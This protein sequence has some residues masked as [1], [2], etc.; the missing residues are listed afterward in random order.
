M[1]KIRIGTRGSKLALFQ[2][3]LV[4]RLLREKDARAEP[5][6]EV[7]TTSGDKFADKPLAEAGG[8]GLF[9]KEIEE[10]LLKG[11]IDLAVHSLK[12]LPAEIPAPLQLAAVLERADARDVPVSSG[13][14]LDELASG[15]KVGTCSPRREAQ[16]LALRKDLEVVPLRGNLDTRLRK[17]VKGEVDATVLA[18]AGLARMGWSNRASEVFEPERFLPAATQGIIGLETRRNGA[19]AESCGAL[20][21]GPSMLA[22]LAERAFVRGVGADCHSAVAA[23]AVADG[24]GI[25]LRALAADIEGTQVVRGE[26]RGKN[27]DAEV[28]GKRLAEKL[29][30]QGAG[31]LLRG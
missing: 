1:A 18:A 22:A 24:E 30:G 19:A 15:A 25:T 17:V 7:I 28:L 10:A 29:L 5:D 6:L 21:H 31:E 8:K 2:A 3:E 9:V 12:D 23:Y 14:K 27:C 26:E 11:R 4:A 13:Q 20:N 16:L